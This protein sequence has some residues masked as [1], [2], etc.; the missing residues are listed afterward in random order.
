MNRNT[1]IALVVSLGVAVML[2]LYRLRM[3]P[4]PVEE[5]VEVEPEPEPE[6]EEVLEPE[7]E[8][9]PAE[10]NADG[11][12]PGLVRVFDGAT[13]IQLAGDEEYTC[14]ASQVSFIDAFDD[15]QTLG[16]LQRFNTLW[17]GPL[18][19]VRRDYDDAEQDF[20]VDESGVLDGDG[21]SDF[22]TAGRTTVTNQYPADIS[23]TN[24]MACSTRK[25]VSSY[26]GYCMRV[27]DIDGVETEIGF[28]DNKVDE[29]ALLAAANG[30][31]LVCV[32]FYDQSE[33]F[34]GYSAEGGA[35]TTKEFRY[36]PYIVYEGEIVRHTGGGQPALW[37]RYNP[38][39]A[40]V[41]ILLTV[42]GTSVPYSRHEVYT[43]G[44]N[45][46]TYVNAETPLYLDQPVASSYVIGTEFTAA[47]TGIWSLKSSNS[48]RI[49]WV[50]YDDTPTGGNASYIDSDMSLTQT[51]FGC[52]NGT[53]ATFGQYGIGSN[54]RAYSGLNTQANRGSLTIGGRNRT[55]T[56]DGVQN[57]VLIS[58]I[59][60]FQEDTIGT[61]NHTAIGDAMQSYYKTGKY[62]G[63]AVSLYDQTGN[64]KTVTQ[65]VA[66]NQLA[67]ANMGQALKH[68]GKYSLFRW[69][70]NLM[71][72][73][74]ENIIT[75][76]VDSSFV[77]VAGFG[78]LSGKN[79]VAGATNQ[80][81]MT[82]HSSGSSVSLPSG[83]SELYYVNNQ[84]V[85]TRLEIRNAYRAVD[86]A[87]SFAFFQ[88]RNAANIFAFGYRD[89]DDYNGLGQYLM[90]FALATTDYSTQKDDLYGYLQETYET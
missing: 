12:L 81:V 6:P 73:N 77:Q 75:S 35:Y 62:N 51:L 41:G 88:D 3:V 34:I 1:L 10:Y 53:E 63:Y 26:T 67:I 16:S 59:I 37:C 8:V 56:G 5:E 15:F 30:G 24:N 9:L 50:Y 65:D 46:S 79:M 74:V 54:T 82:A 27:K 61:G 39:N 68:K 87:I 42:S 21:I 22:V 86:T 28:V 14:E 45:R 11:G 25:I 40:R 20:G 17:D 55:T 36:W 23:A 7:L 4:P 57:G 84:Q 32:M 70:V 72:M 52:Q 33:T 83:T 49:S 48:N 66:V 18:V 2:L 76:G 31:D 44:E 80:Y 71:I 19:R 47:F 58:E 78:D 69:R 89:N 64:G 13:E 85:T 60:G 29:D 90:F 43:P 38:D